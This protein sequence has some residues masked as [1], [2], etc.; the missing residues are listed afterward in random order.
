[1]RIGIDAHRVGTRSTGSQTYVYNLLK[2]LALLEPQGE[3][4]AVYLEPGQS[5]EQLKSNANFQTR[6]IWTSSGALRYAWFFPMEGWRKRFDVFHAQYSLPPF[7]RGHS[8][9][10][11]FDLVYERFPQFF[12]R[13][14]RTQMKFMI[15]QSCQRADHII[16]ISESSKRDLVEIYRADPKRITVTY[17]GAMD[18]CRPMD[19]EQAWNRLREAY[20]LETPYILYVGNLEPRKNLSR[21]LEAFGELRRRELIRHKLVIVGQKD[22]LYN[23]VFE[24]IRTHSLEDDVVLTGYIP[25]DDLPVFYNAASVVVYPSIFEGFG[26]P[27]VEAMACGTP[28]ITSTGS[29]LEEIAKDAAI[30]V[31]PY[32]VSSISAAVEKVVNNV[33]LQQRL[34]QAGLARAAQFSY[35]TMA[36]QTRAVYQ[37]L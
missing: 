16:T 32:S 27:V 30:L 20:N 35:R 15:R 3:K 17:P 29:S 14:I 31:D 8:V 7:L 26:L 10:T 6:T 36:E 24:T 28:V 22:W 9:L 19:L 18:S 23:E 11:V 2:Y 5:I 1:M 21:L 37:Q 4:Y 25:A 33:D 12:R 34:R 13:K